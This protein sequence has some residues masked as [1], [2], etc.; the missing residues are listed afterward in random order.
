[1]LK[2]PELLLPAGSLEKI[3]SAYVFIAYFSEHKIKFRIVRARFAG[4]DSEKN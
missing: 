3:C 1:M 2:S 4:I